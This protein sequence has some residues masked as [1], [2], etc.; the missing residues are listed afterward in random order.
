MLLKF[1]KYQQNTREI[2]LFFS[3]SYCVM[4][5][6][7]Y[8]FMHNLKQPRTRNKLY[9]YEDK[10]KEEK[11]AA[12]HYSDSLIEQKDKT[13]TLLKLYFTPDW[14]RDIY[15]FIYFYQCTSFK[16]LCYALFSNGNKD[17]YIVCIRFMKL[18]VRF[19]LKTS[20]R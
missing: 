2:I 17:M 19:C 15:F 10:W 12:I 6:I 1:V 11:T 14:V 3:M 16:V 20:K 8:T 9:R 13:H 4:R 5:S 7:F 18:Y